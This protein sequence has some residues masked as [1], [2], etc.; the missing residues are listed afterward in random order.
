MYQFE[1]DWFSGHI[2]KFMH[3]LAPLRGSNCKLLEIGTHEGRSA[4]W[5]LENIAIGEMARIVCV[6][7][8]EQPNLRGNLR[9]R[10]GT[11]CDRAMRRMR[12]KAAAA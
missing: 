1:F 11:H 12:T 4:T 7:A 5:L 2:P 8:L 10:L 6:D 9:V 3:Y